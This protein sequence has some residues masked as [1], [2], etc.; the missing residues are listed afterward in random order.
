MTA[1]QWGERECGAHRPQL[2]RRG[3]HS[4]RPRS[5]LAGSRR[6]PA[7]QAE[8]EA[9]MPARMRGARESK[10]T[11]SA[12]RVALLCTGVGGMGSDC[13]AMDW[14]SSFVPGWL[15]RWL[16]CAGLCRCRNSARQVS[17]GTTS[18][19]PHSARPKAGRPTLRV[20]VLFLASQRCPNTL[21]SC[22]LGSSLRSTV[23][24]ACSDRSRRIDCACCLGAGLVLR[25]SWLVGVV[26]VCA[27]LVLRPG[28]SSACA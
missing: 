24:R 11:I 21:P 12:V 17:A 2:A 14:G 26:L 27:A 23:S 6:S 18:H 28:S 20:E 9:T 19:P 10:S 22:L 1:P 16:S 5:G 7:K 25:Q 8:R 3:H 13:S 15:S 4:A